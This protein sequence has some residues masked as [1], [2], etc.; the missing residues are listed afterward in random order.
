MLEQRLDPNS[1]M[2]TKRPPLTW[3]SA[4]RYF[5]PGRFVL[6]EPIAL[7]VYDWTRPRP[8]RPRMF[9]QRFLEWFTRIHPASLV[10]IYVPASAFFVWRGLSHGLSVLESVFLFAFGLFAWSLIEYLLHRF[11]F[12][13]TPHGRI[14]MFYAYLVHGVHHAFPEDDR[15]WLVPPVVSVPMSA[16]FYLAFQWIF[17]GAFPPI[18]AGGLLGYLTYDLSHYVIHRGALRSRAVNAL[19][20]RHMQHHYATPDGWFG[21]STPLWDYVFGTT[22]P[23]K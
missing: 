9:D 3:F 7:A 8:G 1:A 17:K 6:I 22:G 16:L 11:T 12:H 10:S 2:T 19:R 15:R 20:R 4:P 23:R 14:G 13:F 21:V 18:F 5:P